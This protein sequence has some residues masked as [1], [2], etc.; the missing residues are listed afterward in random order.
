[1]KAHGIAQE[2][3]DMVRN[4]AA[5]T[6]IRGWSGFGDLVCSVK[7]SVE[8]ML[9]NHPLIPKSVMVYGLVIDSVTGEL[10]KVT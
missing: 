2:N 8:L 3:I 1:M 6:L 5:L 9:R 7:N 4:I 10:R